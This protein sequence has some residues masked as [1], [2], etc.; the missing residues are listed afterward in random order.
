ML[1]TSIFLSKTESKLFYL[2]KICNI[3][4]SRE[5][6]ELSKKIISR[7]KENDEENEIKKEEINE[8]LEGKYDLSPF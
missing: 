4:D 1:R 6:E 3:G 5:Y 7:N 8:I 2:K